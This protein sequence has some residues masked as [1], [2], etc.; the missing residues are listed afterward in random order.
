M[1]DKFTRHNTPSIAAGSASPAL[2]GQ[3]IL[4]RA[5]R[6]VFN[7]TAIL[8]VLPVLAQNVGVANFPA[9]LDV[10]TLA[11]IVQLSNGSEVVYLDASHLFDD[12]NAT[13]LNALPTR[14]LHRI[15]AVAGLAV[16]AL[17]LP[18]TTFDLSRVE[19]PHRTPGLV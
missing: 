3:G 6:W 13:V 8:A 15:V 18:T 4:H 2:K 17:S 19:L 10:G 7:L 12:P 5:V 11:F 9:S 1:L 16:V 14:K